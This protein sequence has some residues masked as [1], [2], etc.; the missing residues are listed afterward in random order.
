MRQASRLPAVSTRLLLV[1]GLC[2]PALPV[3]ADAPPGQ[4][5]SSRIEAAVVKVFA[6]A[7]PPD[8]LKPWTKQA[9]REVTGSGVVIEGRRIL[10]SA[11]VVSYASQVQ[12][13]ASLAGD[14]V[15][16]A[17]EAIAPGIDLA[18]LKLEDE[19]FFETHPA[20]ERAGA[21][22]DVRDAVMAYGFPTGGTSLSITKGIVSRIEF[23]PYG[24]ELSGLRVQVDAA[25][26]PG[27]SGGPAVAGDKMVGLVRGVLGGAQ[28]IG[29]L[30][31]CE[32]IEAFLKGVAGG[33]RYQKPTMFDSLQTLENPAL[34]AFL[35]LGKSVEGIVVHEPF[36]AGAGSPLQEWD[37]ISRIGDAAV[38]DQ[39]MVQ[40]GG[41]LRV[42]FQYLV[43]KLARD[44]KVP[45]TV[46]RG[47]KP[48][49][50]QL[51]VATARPM[52]IPDLQGAY[53]SW[54]VYGPLAFSTATAQFIAAL[55]GD[56][57]RIG[58]MAFHG[59]PLFVR[60]GEPPAFPGEQLVVVSSPLFPHRLSKGYSNPAGRVLRSVNGV[61]VK[62]L[63]HL[64]EVLRDSRDEFVVL[65]FEL[66][67]G[68]S[69]A[70]VRKEVMAATDEILADNSIRTQGSPDAMEVWTARPAP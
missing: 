23:A 57:K 33:K 37:V 38:D 62:N 68:E 31:P 5:T 47:G 63:R 1:A 67:G 52:L 56:A 45:L 64:V 6:T 4:G 22:P 11:H 9:P 7:R 13:Q 61:R 44:G 8:P 43:Q 69:L 40:V 30:V 16:G 29:Y 21:L 55:G 65:D 51:P 10:T 25:L 53:P 50:V 36:Q 66:R 54:F 28:N 35:K 49:Q 39:G 19:T 59:S 48:L 12:V 26:N 41:G 14:K 60:L 46:V 18:V 58:S 34:R 17:V 32:E 27:N 2:A 20:L 3:R 15:S 24:V 70:F 42:R